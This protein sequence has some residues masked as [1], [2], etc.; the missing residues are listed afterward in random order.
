MEQEYPGSVYQKKMEE[1]FSGDLYDKMVDGC[2]TRN[3]YS[4]FSHGDCWAPN[5]LF[6][7]G[8]NK[9]IPVASKIIDFQLSRFASPALDISFFIYSCTDQMTR[10]RHY[11]VLLKEYHTSLSNLVRAFG[12]D[13]ELVFPFSALQQEM[14]QFA[15][16]GVGMG[17]ESIYFSVLEEELDCEVTGEEEVPIHTVMVVNKIK[18]KEGRLRVTE[19]FKHA[20]DYGYI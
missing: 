4:V 5:F 20:S 8:D 13:P 19:M 1:L 16:H 18:T 11:D 2:S 9:D 6:K 10:A 17:I 14:K 12:S 3:Q 15:R 7:Y